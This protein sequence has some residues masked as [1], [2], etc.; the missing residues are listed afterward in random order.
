MTVEG[1]EKLITVLN[2]LQG[3]FLARAK[4]IIDLNARALQKYVRT[5]KLTGGT[6]ESRLRVRSGRFRASVIPIP[7]ET[8]EDRIEGGISFGTIYGRVHVGPK[9]Q[10]TTITPKRRKYLTIP[11]PAAMTRAGVSRGA[12]APGLSSAQLSAWGPMAAEMTPYGN[13]FVAKSK[14]GNLIVFG[15]LRYAKGK[16]VGELRSQIV[17]LFLLV[18]SVKIKARI[19]PEELLAWIK[20]K[21][22]EDFIKKGIEVK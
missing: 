2:S 19:H 14:K 18:K 7:T 17:P 9:G 16:R 6:T 8:K 11:L 3:K 5:E 12:L 15:N 4:T 21:V 20:P 13:T 22:I 1:S 10:V